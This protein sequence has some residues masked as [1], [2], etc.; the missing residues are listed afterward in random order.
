MYSKEEQ[1]KNNKPKKAKVPFGSKPTKWNN[2]GKKPK[3]LSKSSQSEKSKL[4]EEAQIVFN[5]FI[6]YRDKN[7]PCISCNTK[8]ANFDAG[9]YQS[10]GQNPQLRFNELNCHKQCVKCNRLLS[11]NL[12][13]YRINLIKKI[14][15]ARV[16]ELECDNSVRKYSI[17][18]YKNVIFAYNNLIKIYKEK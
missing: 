3:Q 14:G 6:R 12:K 5:R 13:E 2:S 4:R 8:K 7:M 10:A 1:L 16:E 17:E 11:G 9:H 15:L 18:D